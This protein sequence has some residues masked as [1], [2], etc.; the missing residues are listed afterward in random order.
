MDGEGSPE[1]E[2]SLVEPGPVAERREEQQRD[3]VQQEDHRQ[4]DGDLVIVRA[5]HRCRGGDGAPAADGRSHRDEEA[6]PAFHAQDPREEPARAEA[7]RDAGERV[8][9]A[10]RAGAGDDEEIHRAAQADHRRRE[11]ELRDAARG[12]HMGVADSERQPCAQEQ[13][14]RRGDCRKASHQGGASR[15]GEPPQLHR[16]ALGGF[17]RTHLRLEPATLE[18][19]AWRHLGAKG[20]IASALTA[21]NAASA[22]SGQPAK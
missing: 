8:A 14:G 15:D 3:T 11:Q 7:C 18:K 13:R 1:P 19:G 17:G 22:D 2:P 6:G 5:Q 9:E 21:L 12:A 4:R 20:A 10:G 16:P